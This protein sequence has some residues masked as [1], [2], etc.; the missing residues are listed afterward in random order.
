M[1][2]TMQAA[3]IALAIAGFTSS[4][5]QVRAQPTELASNPPMGTQ[6]RLVQLKPSKAPARR[7]PTVRVRFVPPK[8]PDTGAPGGR[9]GAG[10]RGNCSAVEPKLTALVPAVEQT[11]VKGQE[12][13]THVWGLTV[14][15]YPAFWFYVPYSRM[16]VR[17]VEFVLQDRADNE[18]YQT[19]VT[20]PE[21]P[22]VISLR[23][24]STAAPLEIGK[25]YHWYF[26]IYCNSAKT[27]DPVDPVF[28]EGW[29]QRAVLSPTFE[30][31]LAAAIPQQRSTLYAAN[32]IWYDA[33]TSLAEFR[34]VDPEN[35]ALTAD[36]ADLLQS[37]GLNNV[38]SAPIV[39]CCAPE[40][41]HAAGSSQE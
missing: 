36:W 32:G 4:S 11:L 26:K 30:S 25:L 2:K 40:N 19:P 34:L 41:F 24:P 29:V 21:T 35:A 6:G 13:T 27:S 37:V 28:V 5:A 7:D 9:Q 17:S 10:S 3:A 12:K 8:L 1:Q 22:G 33:L 18:V 20:P 31:Q 16:S 14:A 39:Q 23:L 15:E 38:V